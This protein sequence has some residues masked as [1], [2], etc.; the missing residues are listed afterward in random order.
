MLLMFIHEGPSGVPSMIFT[1]FLMPVLTIP[2]PVNNQQLQISDPSRISLFNLEQR[3][4][5]NHRTDN[6]KHNVLS[7]LYIPDS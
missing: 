4:S 6:I 1:R 7:T 2:L 5:I 3:V